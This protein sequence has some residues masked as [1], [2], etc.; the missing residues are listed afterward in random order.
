MNVAILRYNAGNTRSV[1]NACKRLGVAA[2]I[3]D[4][5]NELKAADRVI[6]PGVGQA[7]TA[8]DYLQRHGLD[9]VLCSLKQ[10][11]LGVCLGMQLFCEHSEEED[12]ACLNIIPARVHRFR[13]AK[14]VPHMG[15]NR[16]VANGDDLFSGVA[17]DAHC[18]FVHSYFVEVNQYT[19]A[20]CEYEEQFSAAMRYKNFYATQFHPEKSAGVGRKILEN[21][22]MTVS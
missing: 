14:K 4:D 8:M 9:A 12:T 13:I 19:I 17:S 11:V 21:F 1:F 10:P 5:A 2:H 18:Y 16:I 3:T 15:W 20:C 6:F 22:L 7:S